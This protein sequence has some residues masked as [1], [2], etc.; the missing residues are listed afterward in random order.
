MAQVLITPSKR[1]VQSGEHGGAFAA[2]ANIDIAHHKG[3]RDPAKSHPRDRM[4]MIQRIGAGTRKDAAEIDEGRDLNV[5]LG[6]D[7]IEGKHSVAQLDGG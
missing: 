2:V 7:G 6:R 1:I 5:E 4:Y 3:S